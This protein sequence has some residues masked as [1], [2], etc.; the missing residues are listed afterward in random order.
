VKE[1]PV[2]RPLVLHVD[3]DAFFASVEVR[4]DPRL[5]G[6]PLA[7][8]GG[9]GKRGVVTTASYPARVFGVH[10]GM[11]MAEALRLCPHL[12]VLPVDPPKY[13]H[14]SLEVLAVLDRFSPR[15]EP[16]SIDE[17]YLSFPPVLE[18]AWEEAAVGI[19]A[20]IR[21]TILSERGLSC[22]VGA[23]ANKLQAKMASSLAKPG[24]VRAVSPRC[25]LE[26]FGEKH[27]SEIPGVGPK[28]GE[29]LARLKILTVRD[30]AE[31][32]PGNLREGFGRWA[33]QLN[34]SAR[35]EDSREVLAAGEEPPA[36]SA[37]H[38]TTFA[39]D[40]AAA[41]FLRAT[42]WLLADRVARRLRRHRFLART[43]AVRFKV[44]QQ[45]FSRQRS[46][47]EPTDDARVLALMAWDLLESARRGR[48]L[49]L[50]GVAGMG[51]TSGEEAPRFLIEDR[52]RRDLIRAGDRIRNRF[53]ERLLLPAGVFLREEPEP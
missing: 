3:M 18:D 53:G 41:P 17:A 25:F 22:T 19:G 5:T 23:A 10:S 7:V 24:G 39:E 14:E 49:R 27:V 4:S 37:G 8:G 16:A 50:L 15:V 48:A 2:L 30:L 35:G 52:R 33:A 26:V 34:A 32:D 42:T 20:A 11:S 13:V 51:L 28:T 1:K 6:L 31:T 45:R 40:V 9:P 46:L 12:F 29:F 44:K 36:K 21:R 47:D 38:E 43:V